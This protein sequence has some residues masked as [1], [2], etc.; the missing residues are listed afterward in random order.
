MVVVSVVKWSEVVHRSL[1]M[2]SQKITQNSSSLRLFSV[3]K[4]WLA[5]VYEAKMRKVIKQSVVST[6]LFV[7][8]VLREP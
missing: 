6:F 8:Y 3:I 2:S 1:L 4:C 7:L 5:V